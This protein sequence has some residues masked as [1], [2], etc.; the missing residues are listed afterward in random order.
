[1]VLT[2]EG[3]LLAVLPVVVAA[4]VIALNWVV[5]ARFLAFR[6]NRKKK[7]TTHDN[8][9]DQGEELDYS[10]LRRE[11]TEGAEAIDSVRTKVQ[12]LFSGV[13]GAQVFHEEVETYINTCVDEVDSSVPLE[14]AVRELEALLESETRN[15]WAL[16][17]AK[18]KELKAIA[19]KCDNL[20]MALDSQSLSQRD[21]NEER[22][23]FAAIL[24][25]KEDEIAIRSRLAA[26]QELAA[27]EFKA[28]ME[29]QAF[30][31]AELKERIVE[32]DRIQCSLD[33]SS[34]GQAADVEKDNHNITDFANGEVP[35]AIQSLSQQL[36]SATS[37]IAS[38]EKVI[39]RN[40]A[41]LEEAT[42]RNREMES[43]IASNHA[44]F[45]E[46]TLRCGRFSEL[47]NDLSLRIAHIDALYIQLGESAAENAALCTSI[48]ERDA[49]IAH[50][51]SLL[52][53][54]AIDLDNAKEK[55]EGLERE[56]V[57]LNHD[58]ADKTADLTQLNSIIE[59][60]QTRT[61][62]DFVHQSLENIEN[63]TQ[64]E[65]LQR[66]LAIANYELAFKM[67]ELVQRDAIIEEI[68]KQS[69][70]ELEEKLEIL[71]HDLACKTEALTQRDALLQESLNRAEHNRVEQKALT[72]MQLEMISIQS[73]EQLREAL[74]AHAESVLEL[75]EKYQNEIATLKSSLFTS[76]ERLVQLQI[77]Q[78]CDIEMLN[79]A[80]AGVE[81]HLRELK[82]D[83]F[84]EFESYN[85]LQRD[86]SSRIAVLQATVSSSEQ[87]II[88]LRSQY[89]Q[90]MEAC[91]KTILAE[92]DL[93]M[94]L[95]K[96]HKEGIERLCLVQE[97]E[98]S[99]LKDAHNEQL[100]QAK[101][102]Q[103]LSQAES[104]KFKAS[105]ECGIEAAQR[106]FE[107]KIHQFETTLAGN[108]KDMDS[109]LFAVQQEKAGLQN[110]L[111]NTSAALQVAEMKIE[112][113][114]KEII[115]LQNQN[116]EDRDI[117]RSALQVKEDLQSKMTQ[118][119]SEKTEIIEALKSREEAHRDQL[120]QCRVELDN[121]LTA[122]QS[123]YIAKVASLEERSSLALD[124]ASKDKSSA[125]SALQKEFDVELAAL[126][127][128]SNLEAISSSQG[129]EEAL[130]SLAKIKDA[131]YDEAVLEF[132]AKLDFTE[133]S[134]KEQFEQ[135]LQFELSSRSAV[136]ESTIDDLKAQ[137]ESYRSNV[138][139]LSAQVKISQ[140][141]ADGAGVLLDRLHT[142]KAKIAFAD[143]QIADL[144]NTIME[145]DRQLEELNEQ[146][147]ILRTQ[148]AV[149]AATTSE[150]QSALRNDFLQ[151]Q[152]KHERA[153]ELTSGLESR[154][155]S[156][157]QVI[158]SLESK[159]QEWIHAVGGIF[160]PEKINGL[161][162][163][164]EADQASTD[165]SAKLSTLWAE[166]E[167]ELK[168]VLLENHRSD[169]SS[170]VS[171]MNDEHA[172]V[173]NALKSELLERS[174]VERSVA[175]AAA[176][177][178]AN[179]Q[180][181]SEWASK[182]DN[183]VK[184]MESSIQDIV[185]FERKEAEIRLSRALQ[186]TQA[187]S[188]REIQSAIKEAVELE[189][190]FACQRLTAALKEADRKHAEITAEWKCKLDDHAATIESL[191]TKIQI[192]QTAVSEG[193][194]PKTLKSNP[195]FMRPTKQRASRS[196][197]NMTVVN[198]AQKP[199]I[200]E[201]RATDSVKSSGSNNSQRKRR[202]STGYS[203]WRASDFHFR[204]ELG[205]GKFGSIFHAV[206]QKTMAEFA[207]KK[208]SR[209]LMDKLDAADDIIKRIEVM[210]RLCNHP[211][212]Q[213]LL[214]S[215]E[216]DRWV[217]IVLEYIPNA[218][219]L[220]IHQ[221]RLLADKI[222]FPAADVA[223]ITSYIANAL[224]YCHSK[225]EI[226]GQV[227]LDKVLLAQDGRPHLCGPCIGSVNLP[228]PPPELLVAEGSDH[229]TVASDSWG[230]GVLAFSLLVGRLPFLNSD[231]VV[232]A[233][234]IAS[235]D[236][237]FSSHSDPAA[238]AFI[239]Q[240]L[241]KNPDERLNMNQ[242]LQHNFIM[243]NQITQAS[244]PSAEGVVTSNVPA[245]HSIIAGAA[246]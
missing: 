99:E 225:G 120:S 141:K 191:K 200:F 88:L 41:Q 104:D 15:R 129:L 10:S 243:T 98:I 214:G 169:M 22:L 165:L 192:Q 181:S 91:Q 103:A 53:Q 108:Q 38:L 201:S 80:L 79:D 65:D 134:L 155:A 199:A 29:N 69:D 135:R 5:I 211:Y 140:F 195:N 136:A 89:A 175:V 86:A 222:L 71:H 131:K 126:R 186:A 152:E 154:I 163:D 166:K 207:I 2:K 20:Q 236:P 213:R 82:D 209:R 11:L 204:N 229:R 221:Q 92:R 130:T 96:A 198:G 118:I 212:L 242:V 128:A 28:C 55:V 168:S 237:I 239:A 27:L 167:N 33:V 182:L 78:K 142:S 238:K 185:A 153:T 24:R 223:L 162:S 34:E 183:T 32:M 149:Q 114:C 66:R 39:Q 160:G 121:E 50:D 240:L 245:P 87:E 90:A 13:K 14:V 40:S 173:L 138:N 203:Y 156:L 157:S 49:K 172:A 3:L 146:I 220:A 178:S 127:S 43:L 106:T 54:T 45:E 147:D 16:V 197:E 158:K 161:D 193:L 232:D 215:F 52:Q 188:Q 105:V 143:V 48:A 187:A 205:K 174:V 68:K 117:A 61:D 100:V 21:D 31:L 63:L 179:L 74:S 113:L 116:K 81:H 224:A 244:F 76:D 219:T 148:L 85:L 164:V 36:S 180:V 75:E 60:T 73:E 176:I 62:T 159:H 228:V 44:A 83:H 64:L 125:I 4:L 194:V 58:L 107:E 123:E 246:R 119:M 133:A 216:D 189:Q 51:Q 57:R 70:I 231:N 17:V 72:D 59:E 139:E 19:D 235:Q 77:S 170:L 145:R 171:E 97:L 23:E 202:D 206:E 150:S 115:V 95:E 208:V 37:S 233:D 196:K 190:E 184:R 110:M 124:N 101:S 9:G 84:A 111:D 217:Y 210:G 112:E 144:H 26:E 151:L 8:V 177:E 47:E 226:H 35:S 230:L 218:T 93:V 12:T 234:L 102:L 122:V 137:L 241:C 67:E 109:Q 46:M 30:E 56:L 6:N 1:M 18:D 132:Q 94:Q 25:Q 7:I 42:D 227:C